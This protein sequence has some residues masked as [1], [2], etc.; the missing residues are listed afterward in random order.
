M[1]MVTPASSRAGESPR[2]RGA[3]VVSR[4]G[5]TLVELLVVIAIIAVLIGLLL[6]AVQSARE[7]ARRISCSNNSRQLG[8][9]AH[10]YHDTRSRFPSGYTQER[11]NAAGTVWTGGSTSG[12]SF[13]GHSVFYFLLPYIEQQA[14][15]S[16]MDAAVP[17]NNRT[18]VVGT[19]AAAAITTF[20]CPSDQFP[21]GNP[22]VFNAN[23]S[24][25]VTSYRVNG[26]SRPVFATSATND[27]MFMATGSQARK[28]ATAPPGQQVG[29]AD[30]TDGTT[31]TILFGEG[32]HRDPN[33]NTFTTA[34]WNSGSTISTWARWYPAGGDTGLGNLMCGAFAEINYRTPWS[35]GA[36]G[37]PGSASA[38]YIHQD[39]R[40]SS[41]GSE[42]PGGANVVMSDGSVR[43]LTNSLAQ[44]VLTRLCV[45]NDGEVLGGG[46]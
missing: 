10:M 32:S 3:C 18:N 23:E 35:H 30:V 36:P 44:A 39:R 17:L 34:G 31:N 24:Y 22:H 28:A 6:P 11:I 8:L 20:V 19:R 27:G 25:G 40:L 46:L 15:F 13:Q 4:G 14:V 33:F 7:A 2:S 42:H 41:I 9:A 16:G 29:I 21:E 12:F 1:S 37:A 38:W 45:R 26:G 5:F 43:F